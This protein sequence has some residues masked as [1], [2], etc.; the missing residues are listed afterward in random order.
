MSQEWDGHPID[1]LAVWEEG[2]HERKKEHLAL[3]AEYAEQNLAELERLKPRIV[4][5]VTRGLRQGETRIRLPVD[6]IF[7]TRA[8]WF[9]DGA[10]SW[11]LWRNSLHTHRITRNSRV[12]QPLLSWLRDTFPGSSVD[13]DDRS[14]YS[15]H[16]PL[17]I[18]NVWLNLDGCTK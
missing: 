11:E 7:C 9:Y 14:L 18:V 15:D 5:Q 8:A 10:E 3:E 12:I 1:V 16:R 2:L 13:V 17:T 4:E 6:D